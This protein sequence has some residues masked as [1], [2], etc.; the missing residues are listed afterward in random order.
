[1]TVEGLQG[2]TATLIVVLPYTFWGYPSKS[3]LEPYPLG[4]SQPAFP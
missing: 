3:G 1:M 4:F 2:R